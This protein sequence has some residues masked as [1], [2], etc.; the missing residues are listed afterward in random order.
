MGY[1]FVGIQG[2]DQ[3]G[4]S[5]ASA[6]DIDG[7]GLAEVL[8][9]AY[10]AD[11][12]GGNS[13]EVYLIAGADLAAADAA[14]GTADGVIDLGFYSDPDFDTASG[15]SYRLIGTEGSDYAGEGVSGAGD[16][17]G[18]G[19]A[20]LIVG[21]AWAGGGGSWSGEAYLISGADLAAADAA[22]G[23]AD[24]VID[25]DF[26]TDADFDR[27]DAGSYQFLGT[28]SWNFAGRSVAIA[29]DVDG[30]GLDDV[31]VGAA[32]A[33]GRYGE[34]Y[35]VSGADLAAADAA[36][37]TA[38]GVIDLD[39]ITDPDFDR[40]GSSSY[41]FIGTEASDYAGSATASAGDV[42]GDGLADLIISAAYADGGGSASGEV[43]L[44]SGADLA[45]ADA[46]DGTADGV[47][48]LD[49][50][51]DPDFD[52]SGSSSYQFIGT[53]ASDYAGSATASAGDVDGDGLADLII[54][55]SAADGGGMSSGEAYLISGADLAAADAA[56]GAAD[57]VIDLDF[58][59]DPDFDRAGSSSYQFIGTEASD[60]AGA[61][62]A[63]AGDVDGDGLADLIVGAAW[64]DG[65]G[66][67]SGE[68]YLI[69]GADL[70]AA[71]A[72]DGAA[73][74]V[75][76]LDFITDPDF[77][78]TDAGSY[79]FVGAESGDQVG[80]SVSSAG[81]V[82]GDGRAD[83]LVGA[84]TADGGGSTSGEASLILASDLADMDAADGTAD[85]VIDLVYA[86]MPVCFV[87]GTLIATP[88]G[89][90]P[91]EGLRPGDLVET[92]DQGAQ[93]VRWVTST[94]RS[95]AD[96]VTNPKWRPVRIPA[97]ALGHKQPATD[98][99]VSRQHR[100]LINGEKAMRRYGCARKFL[101][102]KDLIGWRGIELCPPKAVTYHHIAL[103]PYAMLV[104]NGTP[105]ES[106]W[107]GPEALKTLTPA[108]Q[109]ALTA[110]CPGLMAQA[111]AILQPALAA[112]PPESRAVL[113]GP[114][115]SDRQARPRSPAS[116]HPRHSCR[117]GSHPCAG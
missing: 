24:G 113:S 36:D 43:Y 28:D 84:P 52:R 18:D 108:R 5:V 29:G 93:P 38:D 49:F 114:W 44:I 57:G 32:W 37:G 62:V 83:L 70:A 81:D 82:D 17:D 20:D 105:A 45:A 107:P 99:Y 89:A 6:G 101:P 77:D 75:I 110:A 85:G 97:G 109:I 56:D 72:A 4:F 3:A 47:I 66:N 48:D 23:A 54:G 76:D 2:D 25:L 26:I 42:D 78:R 12:G 92:W 21:A 116:P 68:V 31:I 39:F 65:G 60:G 58:I 55:V 11:G 98:L 8:V 103:D 71:D 63:S 19:I 51:T 53:E 117:A 22:D 10:R 69:S 111:R 14:D 30:D 86:A 96:L 88:A 79:Q 74:G 95:L 90:V 40:S 64:A 73:D 15:S 87:A 59:T 104:A 106:F 112:P 33:G 35:L 13:G 80:W 7:D 1:R 9:G 67:N 102:A 27:S 50:I 41:Q 16:V 91:V 94:I 61:S 46:A 115:G 34:A 100:M